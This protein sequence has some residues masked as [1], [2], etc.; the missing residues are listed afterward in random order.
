MYTLRSANPDV[1]EYSPGTLTAIQSITLPDEELL[2]VQL[3]F[4][5]VVWPI[6]EN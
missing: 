1:N 6:M 2:H 3:R 4:R 5:N